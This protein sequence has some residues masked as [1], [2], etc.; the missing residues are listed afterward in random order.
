MSHETI[1]VGLVQL[2][3]RTNRGE[4]N[5][6]RAAE[7]VRQASSQ[8]CRLVVLPEAFATGLNLPRSRELARPVPG[9]AVDW[10]ARLAAEEKVHLAAGLLEERDGEVF[11][12]AV[13]LNDQGALLHV[14]RRIYVY[15]LEAYFLSSG[16]GCG[17]VETPFG[18]VGL[19]V[20]YDIQFPEVSRMLFAQSVELIVCPSILLR[21]FTSSIC[22]MVRARAAENCCYVLFCS[23]T[24][25]NTLAGLTYMGNSMVLQSPVG[26]APYSRE[27][28]RQEPLLAGADRDETVLVADLDLPGL[29]RLQAANPL[30][31]D[32]QR[33]CFHTPFEN[34]SAS[35]KP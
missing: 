12:S 2:N 8:G 4:E 21:P 7:L 6:V 14:Y 15:D 29:R 26:I 10:L 30:F 3:I 19:I 1:R 32:F 23:A 20:G 18:R 31:K 35:V 5:L 33:G 13:L 34:R 27:F 16:S 17:V 28:R 11:S 24:G 9:P 25:E 22:Q